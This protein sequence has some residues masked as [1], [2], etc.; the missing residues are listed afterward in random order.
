MQPVD[1]RRPV[2]DTVAAREVLL[3]A[4]TCWGPAMLDP[5]PGWW[6]L[7]ID[8][9]VVSVQVDAAVEG[10]R[11]LMRNLRLAPERNRMWSVF[12]GTL[13][14]RVPSQPDDAALQLDGV[15]DPVRP[16]P[17]PVARRHA[18]LILGRFLDTIVDHMAVHAQR[19]APILLP[20]G[21]R[22]ARRT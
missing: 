18:E 9:D 20:P 8:G 21:H 19:P 7:G 3:A 1:L 22:P 2:T 14:L 4:P 17:A 13:A 6:R 16:F 15:I 11:R 5:R 10:A 12:L